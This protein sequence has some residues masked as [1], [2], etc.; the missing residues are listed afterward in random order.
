MLLNSIDK[1]LINLLQA[2]F[3]LKLNLYS[4]LGLKLGIDEIEIIQ[5]I[6]KLKAGGVIRQIGPVL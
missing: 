5:S 6:G 4:E 2:E 1:K 3:P